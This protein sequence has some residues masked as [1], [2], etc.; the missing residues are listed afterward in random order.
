MSIVHLRQIQASLEKQLGDYVDL[1]DAAKASEQDRKNLLLTRALAGY[2][3]VV[4]AHY[5]PKDAMSWVIDG[6]DDNGIDAALYDEAEQRLW[7][8]QSKWHQKDQGSIDQAAVLKYVKGVEYLLN[9]EKDRFNEK[10][11]RLWDKIAEGLDSSETK[12]EFVL[13]H[14]GTQQISPSARQPLDDLCA[15]LNNPTTVAGIRILSQK[16][17]HESISGTLEGAPINAEVMLQNW[18]QIKEPYQ[19]YYGRIN[20]REL[21]EWYIQHGDRLFAKNLRKLISDSAINSQIHKTLGAEPHHFWYFNNGVTVLCQKVSKTLLGGGDTSQ[22]VFS[23]EGMSVVNGAQTVGSV[24]RACEASPELVSQAS[25]MVRFISLEG[26][27]EGFGTEVTRATNTQNR[28]ENRDFA[29]LDP[30]QDRLRRECVFMD[31][32][33][34]YKTGDAAPTPDLGCSIEEATAALACA[35]PEVQYAVRAKSGIGTFWENTTKAPYRL[36]FNPALTGVR[37]WHVVQLGRSI[38]SGLRSTKDGPKD[39]RRQ[40]AVHGNRFIANQVFK[41]LN[42]TEL[43]NPDTPIAEL[44]ETASAMAGR[45]LDAT[46]RIIRRDFSNAYLPPLFKNVTKCTLLDK[47]L[48]RELDG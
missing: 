3:L 17:L 13:V 30:Q 46:V 39:K 14:S 16:E 19:A 40:T 37:M 43:D 31:K 41:R 32:I 6:Y 26:C 2:A 5:E 1:S 20:A 47:A 38:E 42:L 34:A 18:G 8:V 45:I 21:A 48:A 44:T 28:V 11:Q 10:A 24:A 4:V 35:L 15:E 27:P 12:I 33:Y 36:L 22:G 29:A 23:C 25:V 9:G 7:L